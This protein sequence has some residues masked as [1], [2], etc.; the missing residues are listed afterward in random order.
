MKS[1]WVIYCRFINRKKNLFIKYLSERHKK[2]V[3]IILSE[4]FN[5]EIKIFENIKQSIDYY[6]EILILITLKSGINVLKI[7]NNYFLLSVFENEI[8]SNIHNLSYKYSR[9]TEKKKNSF[10]FSLEKYII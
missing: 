4:S 1:Y 6:K 2:Q 7:N 10:I 8:S 3:F 5:N 9:K